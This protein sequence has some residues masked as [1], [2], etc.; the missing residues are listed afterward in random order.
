MARFP[1]PL[2]ERIIFALDVP[3]ADQAK[4]WV[5]KLEPEIRFFKVGL[6]LFLSDGFSIADWIRARGLKVMLDLK[7]YDIPVTVSRAV[8]V[9]RGHDVSFLTVHGVPSILHGAA[10]SAGNM[11]ILAVTVLTSIGNE[12]LRSEGYSA[13]VEELVLFRARKAVEAGCAG[14]VASGQEASIL[15][16]ELGEDFVIV[17]PGIRLEQAETASDD[18]VRVMSPFRAIRNGADYLV[19]GRPI[20]E[21]SN[22]LETVINIKNQ[23]DDA[24]IL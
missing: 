1:V 14:V 7:L 3:S 17:T 8:K 19:V 23:I 12:D 21:S 24:L 22:P 13:T 20:R 16:K 11:R 10:Q 4:Q 5:E 15:R 6:E 18:Q 9:I 2:D